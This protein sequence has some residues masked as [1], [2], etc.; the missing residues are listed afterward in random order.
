M[1]LEKQ[2]DETM[3]TVQFDGITLIRQHI[4]IRCESDNTD[5]VIARGEVNDLEGFFCVMQ[6]VDNAD[7]RGMPRFVKVTATAFGHD[8]NGKELYAD[9]VTEFEMQ[10]ISEIKVETKYMNGV[11]LC[12]NHRT[13]SIR[14]FSSSDFKVDFQYPT[15]E[16]DG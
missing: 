1:F 5:F 4:G 9:K 14:V 6:Y 3:P 7:I 13:E 8:A 11:E 16:E 12:N 15:P 2:P 10:L